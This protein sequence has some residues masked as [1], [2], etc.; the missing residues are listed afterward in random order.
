MA[1]QGQRVRRV[2]LVAALVLLA[3]FTSGAIAQRQAVST[4]RAVDLGFHIAE[5]D[6]EHLAAAR[7][8]GG[9]FVVLVFKW[10]DIEPTPGYYYWEV[11]DAALRAAAHHGVEMIARLDHPPDWALDPSSPTPW[12]IDAYAEFAG[13]MAERYGDRLG[14]VIVGNEPNL[15]LEW[16]G[17]APDGAAYVE[18]LSQIYPAIKA[19]QP[20]L[21]VAMAGLAFTEGDHENRNDLDYLRAVYAAGGQEYF[22]ILA[23]HPYGFGRPPTDPPAANQLNFRRLELH[24]AVMAAAGDGDTPIWITEMGW[25][26]RAPDPS[27]SW[28]VVSA[29]QQAQYTRDAL[30]YVTENSHW[31]PRAALWQLKDDGDPYGYDLWDDGRWSPLYATLRATCLVKPAACHA[32]DRSTAVGPPESVEI[33]AP[34][35]I[36]RLGDIA[37]LH[38]HW[39][40]LYNGGDGFSPRWSGDFFL[41][42]GTPDSGEVTEYD[43]VL[44]TMQVDQPT[45]RVSINGKE[46][47]TL[48]PRTR[49]DPTSTWATQRFA[50]P[51]HLLR[52]GV[53]H[54]EISVSLRNPAWQYAYWRWENVQIRNVRLLPRAQ[55]D[56]STMLEWQALAWP[57]SWGES[58]RLRSGADN[59]FW[60][61]TN[62]RGGLW[63]G[64]GDDGF[65]V[66]QATA[67]HDLL[68]VDI[69]AGVE[70]ELAA[71]DRG[72]RWRARGTERWQPAIGAPGRYAYVVQEAG[73]RFWAGFEAG[74]VWQ[75]R[76]PIGPWTAMGLD[77]QTVTDLVYDPERRALF[78]ATSDAVAVREGDGP[79]RRLPDIPDRGNRLVIRLFLS[80]QGQLAARVG[81]SLWALSNDSATWS[82]VRPPDIARAFSVLKCCESGTILTTDRGL[83]RFD[84]GGEWKRLDEDE[85]LDAAD[86]R[87]IDLIEVGDRF[88]VAGDNRL[89]QSADRGMTWT[90]VDGLQSVVSDLLVP[91]RADEPWLVGTA[92]GVYRS[93]DGGLTWRSTSPAWNILEVTRAGNGRVY[94]ATG[95]GILSA[96]LSDEPLGWQRAQG[97][98]G[99]RIFSVTLDPDDEAM[100][101]AGTWGNDVGIAIDNGARVASL[102]NGLETL[103][104]LDVLHHPSSS[105]IS[106]AT[107]EGVYRSQDGGKSWYPLQG[108]LSSQTVYSLHQDREGILWAGAA[109]GL[110]TSEDMG[111]SWTSIAQIGART[112]IRLG[113]IVSEDRR[114]FWA[115][116]ESDG[117]WYSLDGGQDWRHGGLD[118]ASVYRL[119]ADP[120]RTGRLVAATDDGLFETVLAQHGSP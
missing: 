68:Y 62:R 21:P 78:A 30:E 102:G 118:G 61:M 86:S 112:V 39:V 113:E 34:D 59:D 72:L 8:A 33:L 11:P 53:N 116:T 7:A 17:E 101:W 1:A 35:V 22:D 106:V 47:A 32:T 36:V 29:R 41:D 83:W 12:D 42:A 54:I 120:E 5:G 18:L 97:L 50:V 10:A 13:V 70:G 63:H 15:G 56:T 108:P 16:N 95:R 110:W 87:L 104:V 82:L 99:V 49:P 77:A 58:I 71:T 107:I 57:G 6:H 74:G 73:G 9:N 100:V 37:T 76:S 31:V 24:R 80:T 117:F 25:R 84:G 114:L 66:A 64:Q 48:L 43:L 46:I 27:D 111:Q 52:D 75:A 60:L 55:V 51:P 119:V 96:T 89:I 3:L 98:E 91:A 109:D 26:T 20:D 14:A 103:S 38:P 45:N 79:W 4:Q 69:L 115:G 85:A 67:R 28:Q 19:A 2:A 23:A 40:H 88:V 65:T 92:T 90:E 44:E 105:A 94:L 93:G 81:D